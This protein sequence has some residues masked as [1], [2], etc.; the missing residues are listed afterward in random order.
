MCHH[1]MWYTVYLGC[2]V[3]KNRNVRLNSVIFMGNYSTG[4]DMIIKQKD[5]K[6]KMRFFLFLRLFS[7]FSS[8]LTGFCRFLPIFLENS[9]EFTQDF[10][11]MVFSTFVYIRKHFVFAWR[12]VAPL[13]KKCFKMLMS[14]FFDFFFSKNNQLLEIA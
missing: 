4:S 12:S 10:S 2:S 1:T 14:L 11:F 7:R 9:R 13:P 5:E 3:L 6:K 8:I